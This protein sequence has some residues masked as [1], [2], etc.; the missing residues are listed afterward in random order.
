[1]AVDEGLSALRVLG[2]VVLAGVCGPGEG[3]WEAAEGPPTTPKEGLVLERQIFRNLSEMVFQ[4]IQSCNVALQ[5][6]ETG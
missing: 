2:R 1:M 6:K 3:L 4:A 5:A